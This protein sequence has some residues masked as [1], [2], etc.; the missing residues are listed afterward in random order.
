MSAESLRQILEAELAALSDC[1]EDD[2]TYDNL[3]SGDEEVDS[4]RS[5]RYGL[6][7]DEETNIASLDE[8]KLLLASYEQADKRFEGLQLSFTD[9]FDGVVRSQVTDQ[10]ESPNKSAGQKRNALVSAID[11][12]SY[13]SPIASSHRLDVCESVST[14]PVAVQE[15]CETADQEAIMQELK[16]I[17]QYM[18]EAIERSAPIIRASVPKFA[19]TVIDLS[20]LPQ[21][22]GDDD[23]TKEIAS[24]SSSREYNLYSDLN[25]YSESNG[26]NV[27]AK[28][29][30]EINTRLSEVENNL[31]T[32]AD[33]AI[34]KALQRKKL[35]QA[36][37]LL[38]EEELAI[39]KRLQSLVRNKLYWLMR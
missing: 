6:S 32:D 39:W 8:W 4:N 21:L 5:I 12:E 33:S 15:V 26:N 19:V 1:D 34:E 30:A 10:D 2:D 31:L 37:K 9:G 28:R 16:E 18:I 36:R 7:I 35:L 3:D 13:G 11:D 27:Q 23:Q 20:L 29:T 24:I 17:I 25:S 38:M 14:K 22:I